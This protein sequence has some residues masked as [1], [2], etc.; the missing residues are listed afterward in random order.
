MSVTLHS[1]TEISFGLMSFTKESFIQKINMSLP[2][3][4]LSMW[5]LTLKR[6]K[7]SGG[8]RQEIHSFYTVRSVFL[9]NI[10]MEVALRA[11]VVHSAAQVNVGWALGD[12]RRHDTYVTMKD[13]LDALEGNECVQGRAL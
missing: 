12:Q 11:A 9:Q 3:P 4:D 7:S 8:Q 13:V 5:S 6:T 2:E 10:A 1:Q